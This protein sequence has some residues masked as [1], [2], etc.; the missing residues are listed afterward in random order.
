MKTTIQCDIC[1]AAFE[2]SSGVG[3]PK[4]RHEACVALAAALGR[5]ETTLQWVHFPDTAEGRAA[6]NR[7]RS[8]LWSAANRINTQIPGCPPA[9]RKTHASGKRGSACGRRGPIAWPP[10]CEECRRLNC[11]TDNSKPMEQAS[12]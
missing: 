1:G 8:R 2:R 6:A 4:E 10:T 5:V 3:R 7:I 12:P 11:V 9:K